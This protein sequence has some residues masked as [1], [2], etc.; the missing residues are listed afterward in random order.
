MAQLKKTIVD[1]TLT[2]NDNVHINNGNIIYSTNNSGENRSMVQMNTSN[3]SFYGYGG[4]SNNEGES[5]FDGN[6]V[7]IRSKS[8]IYITDPE[9][10]LNKRAYGQNK[11]LWSGAYYMTDTHKILLSETISSQPN[12]IV[13]VWSMYTNGNTENAAFNHIFVPKQQI[14]SFAGTG[15]SCFLT[16]YAS[17][18]GTNVLGFKYLYVNNDNIVGNKNNNYTGDSNGL[19]L[20]SNRFVLR[21]VIGV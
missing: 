11:V 13:L 14:T 6:E 16:G 7:N 8:G 4:Y 3:Q 19:T 12:G 21:Q 20:S 10:G 17:E 15:V 1:G 5:Y 2:I 9:A 18:T